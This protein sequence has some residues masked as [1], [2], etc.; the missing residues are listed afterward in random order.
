MR[1]RI[2]E[3]IAKAIK[4]TDA[5]IKHAINQAM[6]YDNYVNWTR[7]RKG[8]WIDKDTFVEVPKADIDRKTNEFLEA[9]SIDRA[10]C[11]R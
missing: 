10:V 2:E 1:L 9:L 8:K 7:T 11:F 5:I 6:M 4:S 3:S